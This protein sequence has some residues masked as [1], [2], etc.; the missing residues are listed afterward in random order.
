MPLKYDT[1]SVNI[2]NNVLEEKQYPRYAITANLVFTGNDSID[3]VLTQRIFGLSGE[4][5]DL[6]THLS[7]SLSEIYTTELTEFYSYADEEA[8]DMEYNYD[9]TCLPIS[10]TADSVLSFYYSLETYVGG[11][12]GSYDGYYMNFSIR[13]G[14]L[15]KLSEVYEG[16]PCPEILHSLLEM[17]GCSSEEELI[18]KTSIL[19]LGNLYPTE[20]FLM[21]G[22]CILFRYNTYEIAPYSTGA[23]EV[24][25]PCK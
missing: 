14:H 11:A 9:I 4:P 15:I 3:A 12:H 19:M 18:D 16:D 24:I 17:T 1:V 20:N 25:I 6:M 2:T 8:M 23:I 13:D 7:D 21:K 5:H 22:D 10:Q